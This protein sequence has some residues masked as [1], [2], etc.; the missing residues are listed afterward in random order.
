ML[1]EQLELI[2][3]AKMLNTAS[4]TAHAF[5]NSVFSGRKEEADDNNND[6]NGSSR[7]ISGL[8]EVDVDEIP[9]GHSARNKK[10]KWKKIDM[11]SVGVKGETKK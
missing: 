8:I 4:S 1:I 11:V 7:G 10:K 6:D 2:T 3:A 5:G 9:D